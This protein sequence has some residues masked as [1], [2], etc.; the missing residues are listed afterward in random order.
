VAWRQLVITDGTLDKESKRPVHIKDVEQL[1]D[2]TGDTLSNNS[3]LLP[4]DVEYTDRSPVEGTTSKVNRMGVEL[5]RNTRF[6]N[7]DAPSTDAQCDYKGHNKR[8]VEDIYNK[9]VDPVS[10]SAAGFPQTGALVSN[11][12]DLANLE[13]PIIA[14]VQLLQNQK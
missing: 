5:V 2:L 12:V 1:T 6:P 13:T 3:P 7:L 8:S 4:I 9:E 14:L 11:L 10:P